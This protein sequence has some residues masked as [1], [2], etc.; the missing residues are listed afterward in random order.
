MEYHK[1]EEEI[2]NEWISRSTK[3]ND[4][5]SSVFV[6][7]GL[8]C[9]GPIEYSDSGYWWRN[10]GNEEE[11]W[12]KA[13]KRILILTK[14]LNDK[15]PWDIREETGRK[16]HSGEGNIIISTLFYKN[17][18]R[19]VFGL[20]NIDKYGVSPKF[21][22]INDSTIYQPFFDSVPIVRVN[23]KKQVGANSIPTPILERYME[24]YKD[25]LLKQISFYDADIIVCC[26][27][28]SSI[29]NFIQNNYIDDLKKINNWIYYSEPM[30]KAVI[31]SYHLSYHFISEKQ[32]YSDF[33]KNYN[34]FLKQYPNFIRAN[35]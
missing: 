35:R 34:Q 27:G 11:L 4:G 31:D 28:S 18:M 15:E 25:L 24:S 33:M 7:D 22:E 21:E 30:N 5:D 3:N 17:Y 29:K 19:L 26:G 9:R 1:L 2:F 14:D 8:L 10:S 23:C 12:D 20:L 13:P 16:N 6:P 32:L